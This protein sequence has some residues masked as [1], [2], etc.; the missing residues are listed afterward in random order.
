MEATVI[1]PSYRRPQSLVKVLRAVA[2]QSAA[3]D[4]YEVLVVDNNSRDETPDVVATFSASHTEVTLHYFLEPLQGVSN[5]RNR[6]ITEAQGQ[7]LCFL[8][9]DSPPD[10]LWLET[11]LAAFDD[12][13]VGCAG[14]PSVLDYQGLER[15]AWLEGDLQGLL[16]GY[17]LPYRQ[18]TALSAFSEFPLGCNVA[19]RRQ[20][21]AEL[22]R[23]R[24]DLDRCGG[25]VLAAGDTEMVARVHRAGWLVLY[26]PGAKVNHLVEPERIEKPYL[27]RIGKGL[28]KSHVILTADTGLRRILRAFASDSWYATRMLVAFLRSSVSGN[29]LWFD[30]YMRFWMVSMRIP[31]RISSLLAPASPQAPAAARAGGVLGSRH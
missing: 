25:E 29:R 26:V 4:R 16:S 30:D 10:V 28:A 24:T 27:Y 2:A 18:P 6:G 8:D 13:R 17:G 19:F 21:F 9:D 15:P 12:Q 5:A 23:L 22:G 1:I 3:R 20:I 31:L 14:G 7:I 11:L